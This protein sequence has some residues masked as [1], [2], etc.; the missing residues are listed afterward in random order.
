MVAVAG[1]RCHFREAAEE[2][3]SEFPGADTFIGEKFHGK[4]F[5]SRL[6][7]NLHESP[8]AFQQGLF[9]IVLRHI[10]DPAMSK[11]DQMFRQHSSS[12]PVV[13]PDQIAPAD[14][15]RQIVHPQNRK[16]NFGWKILKV[17][18]NHSGR[19]LRFQAVQRQTEIRHIG[20]AVK[21]QIV[22]PAER[23]FLKSMQ[24]IRI[25][26]DVAA[27]EYGKFS[28]QQRG[29][30]ADNAAASAAPPFHQF[31]DNQL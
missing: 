12:C 6:L 23:S 2:P 10:D 13:V 29:I 16:W 18:D 14:I 3:L 11:P 1:D 20:R 19:I 7:Q 22:A 26:T 21:I 31:P 30:S 27:H 24:K 8:A 4:R 17:R 5:D 25:I 15:R 9:H 28:F